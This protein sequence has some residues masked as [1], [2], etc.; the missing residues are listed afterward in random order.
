MKES[1]QYSILVATSVVMLGL[2][3]QSLILATLIY[4]NRKGAAR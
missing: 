4:L 3:P 1:T 2:S